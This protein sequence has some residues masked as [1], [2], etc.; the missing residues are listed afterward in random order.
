[1]NLAESIQAQLASLEPTS[2]ELQDESGQHLGHAGWRAGGSH[3]RLVIVSP[4]FAGQNRLARHRMVYDAL[5]PLIRN[6]IHA[7]AI[8]AL[9][10]DEL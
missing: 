3:F 7:L 5:G 9:A 2:V 6:D 1:M 8:H 4:R 10:P